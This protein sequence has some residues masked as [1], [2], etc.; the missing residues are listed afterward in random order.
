MQ[1]R[2]TVVDYKLELY[3]YLPGQGLKGD[4]C[5]NATI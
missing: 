2:I 1:S 4:P 5:M 3:I